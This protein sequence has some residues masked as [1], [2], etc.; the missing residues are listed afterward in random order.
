MK[1]ELQ[2]ISPIEC[3]FSVEVE[4]EKVK[5]QLE[6]AYGQLAGKVSVPGFR[7][8]KVPR[9]ILEQR[10]RA[11]VE[12]DV[13]RDLE[14][15]GY[16]E[17]LRKHKVDVVGSPHWIHGVFN[18]QEAYSFVARVDIRPEPKLEAYK[19]L[20]LSFS[21]PIVSDEDIEKQLE[22]MQHARARYEEAKGREEVHIG[23]RVVVDFV[24]EVEGKPF[25][26]SEAKGVSVDVTR[27][28]L[29][30]GHMPQLEAAKLNETCEFSHIFGEDAPEAF[31][32]GKAAQFKV[33]VKAIQERQ[34]PPLDDAFAVSLNAKTL[35]ELRVRMR[36]GMEKAERRRLAADFRTQAIEQLI[37][38]NPLEVPNSMVERG[39]DWMME[40]ALRSIAQT[41]VDPRNLQMDW[42]TIREEMR[43]KAVVEVKGQLLLSAVA[44]A[45]NLE[46]G[47][48][49]LEAK[50]TEFAEDSGVE[51][52]QVKKQFTDVSQKQ[53]LSQSILEEKALEFL[54]LH[55]KPPVNG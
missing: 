25:K 12:A 24:A 18:A 46:V 11:Q 4:A 33:V 34:L 7:A 48:V 6:R 17:A 28:E 41:G 35:E 13:V 39:I 50:F 52:S 32:H 26:G 37:E 21:E 55:A 19:E 16:M 47:D 27:G 1:V 9:R 15:L 23:D 20:A 30:S 5:E 36:Q 29:R 10:F 2:E 40:G 14:W 51:L 44:K 38:K 45:E 43:P 49:D 31:L 22:N 54:K 3:R 8:G 42:S 53:A